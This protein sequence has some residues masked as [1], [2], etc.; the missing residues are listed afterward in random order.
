MFLM[1][2]YFIAGFVLLF[3]GLVRGGLEISSRRKYALPRKTFTNFSQPAQRLLKEYHALPI[4][5]RPYANLKSILAAMDVKHGVETV[6]EHYRT[7]RYNDERSF[8]WVC[9]CY[10][11][12][13]YEYRQIHTALS[14]IEQALVDREHAMAVAAVEGGLDAIEQFTKDLRAERDLIHDVTKELS[15]GTIK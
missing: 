2:L 6:N 9:R 13:D 11:V 15:R 3:T 4:E 14:E 10:R 1:V 12:C 5:N 8:T 7:D